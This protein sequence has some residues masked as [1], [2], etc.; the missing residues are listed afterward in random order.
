MKIT[1]LALAF[2]SIAMAAPAAPEAFVA[3]LLPADAPAADAPAADV[4]VADVPFVGVSFTDT[5]VAD[6]RAKFHGN[7]KCSISGFKHSFSK[8]NGC[9]LKNMGGSNF[10][11]KN[12][13][14]CRLTIGRENPMRK[15]VKDFDF[16]NVVNCDY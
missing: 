3:D 5:P 6:T 13:L 1:I 2:V 16:A 9:C 14:K 8:I 4:S 7:Y 15:C 11:K 10:D 12:A